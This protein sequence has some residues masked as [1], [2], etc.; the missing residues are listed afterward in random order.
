MFST[1]SLSFLFL[2]FQEAETAADGIEDGVSLSLRGEMESRLAQLD[3][4]VRHLRTESDEVWKTFE[5]AETS[6]LQMVSVDNN[7]DQHRIQ[8]F[9]ILQV[10][11]KDW[12][13]SWMFGE[14]NGSGN[15]GVSGS[16][17]SLQNGSGTVSSGL[18]TPV[19]TTPFIPKQPEQVTMKARADRHETEDFYLTVHTGSI[20]F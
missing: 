11:A 8:I 5:T 17:N 20:T 6:L 15:L 12:D 19:S 13:T 9:C 14:Q 18:S 4:R 2:M 1:F 10:D 7:R 3:A 16:G